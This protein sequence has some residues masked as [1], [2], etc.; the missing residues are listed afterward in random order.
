MKSQLVNEK[1]RKLGLTLSSVESC[2]GGAFASRITMVSGAS[3]FY[4]GGMVTYF[5]EEKVRLL[6]LKYADLDQ[7]GVVSK[8]IA[9][10][11]AFNARKIMASDYCVSFTGNA[12]PSTM[13]DKPAGLVYIAVC[14]RRECKVQEFL[15]EGNREEIINQAVD[16]ALDMLLEEAKIEN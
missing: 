10:Q 5:T 14:S 15:F 12:G 16:A 9:E 11:M 6:G 3:H 1:F 7:N 13:E 4:K 2:T 8:E